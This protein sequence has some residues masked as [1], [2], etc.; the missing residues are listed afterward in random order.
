VPTGTILDGTLHGCRRFPAESLLRAMNHVIR[1]LE[2]EHP[3]NRKVEPQ[4]NDE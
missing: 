2:A 1:H 3:A 4:M